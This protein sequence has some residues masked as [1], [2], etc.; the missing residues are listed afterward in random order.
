MEWCLWS[1]AADPGYEMV[2]E[3]PNSP[4][5]GIPLVDSGW[6]KLIIHL[7]IGEEQL[8]VIWCLIVNPL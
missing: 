1:S 2:L 6:Y 5:V 7:L 8:E 4:F 3:C